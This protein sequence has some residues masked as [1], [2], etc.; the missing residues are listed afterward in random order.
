MYH[1]YLLIFKIRLL[2][3]NDH[4]LGEKLELWH[5]A[6]KKGQNINLQNPLKTYS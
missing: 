3:C 5:I 1:E 4:I 6:K 2:A